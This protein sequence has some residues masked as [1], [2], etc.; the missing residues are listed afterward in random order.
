ML[1]SS[2]MVLFLDFDGVLRSL[3]GEKDKLPFIPRFERVLREYPDIEIVISSSWREDHELTSL[4]ALF[5]PDISAR[6]VDKTP[7]FEYLDH[8]HVRQAEVM[9]WLQKH[10][11]EAES[12]VALDD[13]DWLFEP[14]HPNLILVDPQT[15]FDQS[16][17]SALRKRLLAADK[18]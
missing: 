6:I 16:A 7:V 4:R 18:P 15:G 2:F 13:D 11:K 3:H 12:W 9:A 10:R 1:P 14:G 5:S 17:E 8:L